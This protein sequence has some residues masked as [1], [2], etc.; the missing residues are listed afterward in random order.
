MNL[1][2]FF[3]V[4]VAGFVGSLILVQA[5]NWPDAGTVTAIAALGGL[6]L[7]DKQRNTD[8]QSC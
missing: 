8:Y 4:F 3:I 1:E 5:L 2:A 6:L 7:K